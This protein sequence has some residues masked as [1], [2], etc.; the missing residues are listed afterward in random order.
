MGNHICDSVQVIS[1][2]WVIRRPTISWIFHFVGISDDIGILTS[3]KSDP[4]NIPDD[5][6]SAS[7]SSRWY[8]S[9]RATTNIYKSVLVCPEC[10]NINRKVW[11]DK[12]SESL[13]DSYSALKDVRKVDID[14]V[15]EDV[16]AE[17]QIAYEQYT[18]PI[19]EPAP[20]FN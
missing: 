9:F 20:F 10:R 5:E 12:F 14:T 13:H 15:P 19:S 1:I 6:Y 18:G 11:E 17:F 2:L 16:E 3:F 4:V 8:P 7:F